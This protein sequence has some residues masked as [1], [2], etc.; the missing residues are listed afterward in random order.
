MSTPASDLSSAQRAHLEQLVERFEQ[1]WQRGEPPALDDFLPADAAE[2]QA[3]LPDLVHIDLERRL[4]AGAAVRVETYLQRYPELA[5]R[6]EVVFALA[7]AEFLLRRCDDPE[8]SL[9]EYCRRFP[10]CAEQLRDWLAEGATVLSQ[11]RPPSVETGPSETAPEP[12]ELPAR[13]GRYRVTALLGS[14]G[15]GVVYKG[16]DDE[17]QRHVA[18]KVPHRHLLAQPEALESY[19]KEAR[20][21][22][23]LDH[24][25]IVPVYDVGRT[26]DGLCYVVSKFIA[27]S[28][29][30][31]KIEAGRPSFP[32]VAALVATV[33]EA[34]HHAHRQGL[35]HRDIKPGNILIDSAGQAYVADFGLALREEDFG[36]GGG[37]AGTPAYMSPEQAN[38]EGHRVDGRS[39]IFSLGVVFYELLTGRRPFR[40]S[41]PT[42][43]LVHIVSVE[44]RPP[45]QVDDTI[46]KELERI[47]LKALSKRSSE[48]YTTA[49]DFADD[50]R[51][52]Q[53]SDQGQSSVRPA[54]VSPPARPVPAAVTPVAAGPGSAT[55]SGQG[56]LKIVPRGLRSFDAGDA[57]FFLELLPGP[58]DRDGLPDSIRFWKTRIEAT[59]A[60]D[61]FA[62]GLLY[63]PSGC[64]KSSLVKAGLLPRL[65][66]HVIPVYIE[67]TAAETETRLL[68]G[69]RKRCSSL[70]AALGLKDTLAALRRG[71]GLDAGRK[72]LLV[73]DQF[74]QWLHARPPEAASELVQALR[75]CEG[76][77]VQCV[78]MVRDDFWL[79]V[80]R[81]LRELEVDIVQ[82]RNIALVDLFDRDHARKVLTA[83][84][85]AFG[86]VPHQASAT[87]REQQEFIHQA[88]A[89][90]AQDNTVICVRLALFAEM[91][92]GRPWTP[93]AL[94]EVGGTE[95]VGVTFLEDTFSSPAANPQHRLHQKAAR[96]VLK[97]LLPAAGTD[98]K[99]HLRGHADLLAASGYAGR[100]RE[101]DELLRILD[102]E[103]RLIT[104]TDPEGMEEDPRGD[105]RPRLSAEA[106]P[107]SEAACGYGA[108]RYYQLTHD[109]LV[110]SLRQWL[111]RK[112]KETRRGRAELRLAERSAA[113]HARP[114]NR[115]LPAWWE[116]LNIRLFTRP[117]DWTPPQR[118]MM[119]KATRYHAVRGVLLTAA[120]ALL[121]GT[122][123]TVRHQVIADREAQQAAALEH[124]R[125]QHADALVQRL[126][127]ADTAGVPAVIAAMDDYRGWTD[128]L[129]AAEAKQAPE[130]SR[131]KLHVSLALLP[132]DAGQVDYLTG[133]LLDARPHEVPVLRQ[134]L[135]PHQEELRERLWQVVEH[136]EQ[137]KESQ[138]LRAACALALYDPDSPRWQKAGSA[139]VRQL[140]M[141]NSVHLGVWMDGF[142]SVKGQLIGPLMDVFRDPKEEHAAERTRAT[143]ILADYAA[144]QPERLA[145]LL[146]DADPKQYA[147]LFPLLAAKRERA[148]GL[149]TDELAKTAGF[150][151]KDTPLDPSWP[152]PDAALVRQVETAHGQVAE[153][154][155]FCQTLPLAQFDALAAA[156]RRCGYRPIRLRPYAAG[157]AVQVAAVWSRDGRDG[158]AAHG[159]TAAE[160]RRQDGERRKQ[161]YQPVDVAGYR[162]GDQERYAALWVK[163]GPDDEARLYV[164][165]SD[166]RHKA[167]GWGP[168]REAKLNPATLQVFR[169]SE[170]AARY[171]SVFRKVG[172]AGNAAGNDDEGTHADR[173]LGDGLPVDVSLS[174]SRQYIDD[175]R[176]E[177]LAW[178]SGSPWS[179]LFLRG[180]HPLLPHP[181][182][183]Y[184]GCFLGSAAFDH[185]PAFGLTPEQQVQRCRELA[186]HGY[187]PAALSV[188]AVGADGRLVAASLWHRPIIPDEVKER[189]AKRQANAAVALLRLGRAERVWPLLQHRPDPRLRS[190]LI[191][192]LSPL[193][194]DP[195][196][197]VQ[198][199]AAEPD[200]SARRALL[201]GLGEFGEKEFPARE[202][203]ALVPQLLALY[204]NDPDPGIH[205]AVAWLLRQPGWQQE[206]KLKEI[207]QARAKDE[208]ERDQRINRIRAEVRKG[209]GRAEPQWYVNGQGQ[210]LVVVPGPVEYLMGSPRTEAGREN[211]PEGPIEKQHRRRIGRSFAIAA[212]EVTVA[213]FL[214]FRKD[215][216]YHKTYSPTP[217]HPVILV[218]WYDAAAY[219]NWLSKQEGIPEDQWCYLPN[220]Q[221][222]FAP[223]MRMKP[224]YLS[225]TGY[226]L[227]TEAE[228]EYACRAGAVTS[229]Y[230]GETEELL[231]KYAWYTKNSQDRGML[232]PG[233][234]KPNDLG[235]FDMLGNAWGWC[236]DGIFYYPPGQHGTAAVDK[237]YNGDMKDIQDSLGRVLRGGAFALPAVLVRSAQRYGGAPAVHYDVVGFRPARTF[238]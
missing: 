145:A 5:A 3:V 102:G 27:G 23:R 141:E 48:R 15:F 99:G 149:L 138:R 196:A 96:A 168:L 144:E 135:R 101:F 107:T 160:V 162:D 85:G 81:F 76:G 106:E 25:H 177:L 232:V 158:Q 225:L 140:V 70:P 129:L 13:L 34:L 198:R 114:E 230:Y 36:R 115:H 155:A 12:D 90:L 173:G 57:D 86:K 60:D 24:P 14:G 216:E 45:R 191:H 2:R 108:E 121:A 199:L 218:T 229:R 178:L 134:A 88:V 170:G 80:S 111:T 223:G 75:Q 131:R 113:W 139:V 174:D 227:P 226:R 31:T 143:E 19:L 91:M 236:Q 56:P 201:L 55:D 42:D 159:L 35:V 40:A 182:R 118:Q 74:E 20:V 238:D 68:N 231:G 32:E 54:V 112:Q 8:L 221:G 211:G 186:R 224:N 212:E 71:Q 127:D 126:I 157:D 172:P 204:R 192:R 164:G 189:L 87:R 26:D 9:D 37:F 103:L 93:A 78:L 200:V 222:A 148:V 123:L 206:A 79:A 188:A 210:T 82:S 30:K 214:R 109:Y 116:W 234:L 180:V 63:G 59:D 233:G 147:V 137:G 124:S 133:R 130:G 83:Y 150:D 205:G 184:A 195:R 219:C 61:T 190:Y 28:D 22:A 217:E 100:P 39:D 117:R 194:A 220:K 208:Q 77:R 169:D 146:A 132:V 167:D 21:L 73:L 95:G 183:S 136:P 97:A 185:A 179:G 176:A 207:D 66:G 33:A 58:R 215:H 65:A 16:Y 52:W 62:V 163:G 46:P 44:A 166:K 17:L 228:W 51:H 125:S 193:G 92:K 153:R 154:F 72:V 171:S 235:L 122:V 202:R 41:S 209:P 197:L 38:G 142:Q 69:L 181:E 156:L 94:K 53:A 47:C 50:L 187:R 10:H 213:Q 67:A 128:P 89:G 6:P 151:W 203:E 105:K 165:V 161:G 152:A 104:P 175:A 64:G 18:I 1:A 110:P 11:S 84:G 29:L 49:A 119:R 43:L 120:V 98:I 7:K 4:K 237:E